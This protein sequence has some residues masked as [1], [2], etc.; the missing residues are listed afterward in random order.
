[1]VRYKEAKEIQNDI[2]Q[3]LGEEIDGVTVYHKEG[4]I[5]V[6]GVTEDQM[7]RIRNNIQPERSP[8]GR[9]EDRDTDP[10]RADPGQQ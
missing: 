4:E 2:E 5:D 10:E 1:M 6:H 3:M 9:S 7:Q 8:M